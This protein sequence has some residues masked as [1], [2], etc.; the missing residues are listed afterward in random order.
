MLDF[1]VS[2]KQLGKPINVDLSLGLATA[3]VLYAA[4]E[5]PQLYELMDRS[6]KHPGDVQEV[7]KVN[8]GLK[9]SQFKPRNNKNK[10]AGPRI[11]KRVRNQ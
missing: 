2:E 8:L 1:V 5:F 9:N 4:K 3:P 6:F 7:L 11:L 10:T